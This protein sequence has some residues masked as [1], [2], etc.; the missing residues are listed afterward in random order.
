MM[1]EEIDEETNTAERRETRR[2]CVRGNRARK[3]DKR[4]WKYRQETG[5]SGGEDMVMQKEQ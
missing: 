1:M 5:Y 2:W 4:R 3:E